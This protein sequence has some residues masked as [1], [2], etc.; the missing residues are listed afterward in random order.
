MT[1]FRLMLLAFIMLVPVSGCSAG[2][3]TSAFKITGRL[4]EKVATDFEMGNGL[5]AGVFELDGKYVLAF[6]GTETGSFTEFSSDMIANGRQALGLHSS[7]YQAAVSLARRL[8][9]RI[10]PSGSLELTGHS[11]GGG[12]A[13]L[14]SAVTGRTAITFSSSPVSNGTL[15]QYDRTTNNL[16]SVTNYYVRGD[17]VPALSMLY[18]QNEA[19]NQIAV[20]SIVRYLGEGNPIGVLVNHP[21]G[22]IIPLLRMVPPSAPLSVDSNYYGE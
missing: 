13:A 10:G 6:A 7:Q 17:P 9:D 14:G 15:S 22:T 18:G 4:T 16:S 21:I 8:S 5:R 2:Q 20:G 3:P 11:L 12:L 1:L 19:P